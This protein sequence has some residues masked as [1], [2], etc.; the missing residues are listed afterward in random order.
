MYSTWVTRP[1]GHLGYLTF[2]RTEM[3][4][5]FTKS[6]DTLFATLYAGKTL[7][8]ENMPELHGIITIS[9]QIGLF[10]GDYRV[11]LPDFCLNTAGKQGD[12]A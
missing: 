7:N 8:S 11:L 12:Y 9:R 10:L 1:S 6:V 5:Y 4:A 3:R 2:E